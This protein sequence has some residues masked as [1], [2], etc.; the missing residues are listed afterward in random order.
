MAQSPPQPTL[1]HVEYTR[2]ES[3][4]ILPVTGAY[5]GPN[6]RNDGL[7]LHFFVE[8]ME[9]PNRADFLPPPP[10]HLPGAPVQLQEAPMQQITMRRDLQ[11]GVT[12][13]P[14]QALSIGQWMVTIAQGLL[15]QRRP[16][17]A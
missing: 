3:Y 1:P 7:I 16:P 9:I 2:P 8:Y 13:S 10:G 12:I 15:A 4:K 17:N 6:T 11:V 5:G 14:E